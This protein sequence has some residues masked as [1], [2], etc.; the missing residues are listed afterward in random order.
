METITAGPLEGVRVIDLTQCIAGPYCTKLFADRGAEVI[1]FEAPGK[2]DASRSM[3]P[4]WHE[5]TELA[6]LRGHRAF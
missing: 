3:P 5:E 4:F 2:G 1:K 6:A